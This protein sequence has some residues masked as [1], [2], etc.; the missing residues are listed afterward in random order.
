MAGLS[1]LAGMGI[2]VVGRGE[3]STSRKSATQWAKDSFDADPP[4][5]ERIKQQSQPTALSKKAKKKIL[6]KKIKG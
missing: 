2:P 4:K 5:S 1:F 6:A 3:K